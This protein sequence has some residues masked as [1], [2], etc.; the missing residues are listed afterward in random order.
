MWTTGHQ[1]S[2]C[3][4]MHTTHVVEAGMQH[5]RVTRLYF[6]DNWLLKQTSRQ[7]PHKDCPSNFMD[8]KRIS[9]PHSPYGAASQLRKHCPKRINDSNWVPRAF[10]PSYPNI[11]WKE[12]RS[13]Q[14]ILH[15]DVEN[16]LGKMAWVVLSLGEGKYICGIAF[17]RGP[18]QTWWVMCEDGET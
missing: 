12:I 3:C 15:G 4:T 8:S 18:R 6:R 11:L 7:Q 5:I 13:P 17:I 14:Y 2:R 9:L 1:R 16:W 10:L